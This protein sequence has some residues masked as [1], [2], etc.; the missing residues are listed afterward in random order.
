MNY[1]GA[2]QPALVTVNSWPI[3]DL[4]YN[5]DYFETNPR[6]SFICKYSRSTVLFAVF[7]NSDYSVNRS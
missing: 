6:H 3:F 5:L 2:Q 1:P 7:W 4:V